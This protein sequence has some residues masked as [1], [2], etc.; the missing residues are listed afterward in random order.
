M[1]VSIVILTYNNLELNRK[2]INAILKYTKGPF[3]LI[4]VDNA[5]SDGTVE[6]LKSIKSERVKT[7]FN[8]ENL[9]FA[10]GNNIGAKEATSGVVVFLNNDTEVKKGW[11]EPL[12][13]SLLDKTTGIAGSKLLYPNGKIQHAGIVISDDL[14]PRH[15]YRTLD[16]D[17][18]PANK[19]REYQAVTGACLAIK[20]ELFDKVGGFDEGYTNGLED[21]D[22]CFKVKKEDYKVVYCPSSVV[23]HYESISKDRFKNYY[24][25]KSRYF[26]KWPNIKPDEDDF[27]RKDGFGLVFIVKQHIKNRY[28][29]G[30][31]K[32][33]IMVVLSN[34][35]S[36]L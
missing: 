32:D 12:L 13:K 11:L 21:I 16:A 26:E 22:L 15:I 36:K 29:T 9:G 2:C 8:N 23:V 24:A 10:R 7:V 20:K 14:V 33:K 3:E 28:L 5:S 35:R 27:Y 31:Y 6:Y 4:I 34:L 17:W 25:N 1:N 18:P 19:A 30:S